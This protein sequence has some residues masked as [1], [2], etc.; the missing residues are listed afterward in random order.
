M[1]GGGANTPPGGYT[2]TVTPEHWRQLAAEHHRHHTD[3]RRCA[4][5]G[6]RDRWP[7]TYWQQ[8]DRQLRQP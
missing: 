2:T 5:P 4:A 1:P 8:A 7:C 6:C 3:P